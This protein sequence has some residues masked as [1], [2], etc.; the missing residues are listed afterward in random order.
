MSQS[1]YTAIP[2]KAQILT[3]TETASCI[4]CMQICEGIKKCCEVGDAEVVQ[5]HNPVV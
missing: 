3:T 5:K 2:T 1:G 4:S